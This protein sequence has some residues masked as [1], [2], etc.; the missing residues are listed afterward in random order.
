MLTIL[1]QFRLDNRY[2]Q[3][4]MA[5]MLELNLNT[6]RNYELGNRTVPYCLLRRFLLLRGNEDDIKLANILKE[7]EE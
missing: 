4:E 5:K 1:K 6:Y 2:T 3:K 7:I